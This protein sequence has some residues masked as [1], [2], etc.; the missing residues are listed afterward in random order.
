VAESPLRFAEL[1][2]AGLHRVKAVEGR[3]IQVIQDE[4]GY[5]LGRE[6]G[7]IVEYW[8]KGHLPLRIA[9]VDLLGRTLV[10]RGQLDRD[11]LTAF[12]AAGGHPAPD[13]V[14][15]E[16]FAAV[17]VP[18]GGGALPQADAA[19][20]PAGR[21]PEPS[22]LP[23]GSLM[24]HSR[25]PFF[26]GR[27]EDLL[28][29]ARVLNPQPGAAN[30]AGVAAATGL[31]GI[32]KTQLA[33]EFV[34]RYGQFFPDGVFWLR[35]ELPHAIPAEVARCGGG[36]GLALRPDFSQLAMAEQVAMV[37]AAWQ[38]PER[39]LLIFD[40]CED[41][42]LVQQW[43]P[44][45]GGCR[46]LVTSRLGEWD[47][48]LGV[49]QVPLDVFARAESVALLR[50]H[51][52]DAEEAVFD[53]IAAVLGDLP[54]ALHL[55][56]SYLHRYRRAVTPQEYL[57]AVGSSTLLSHPSLQSAGLSPT[58]HVQH[59]GRTF[60]VSYE[61]LRPDEPRDERAV[62]LL[63]H[64]ACF[65]PGEPV[66]Y[67]VLVQTLALDP[68]VAEDALAAEDAFARLIELG[69]VQVEQEKSIR[70]HRL[71][72]AFARSMAPEHARSAQ[73][74]IEAVVLAGLE[75]ANRTGAPLTLLPGNVHMRHVADAALERDPAEGAVLLAALARHLEQTGD[76]E[77]A[78]SE[79]RRALDV[80]HA[81]LH[82]AE[83]AQC[84][85][86]I[87][88]LLSA[89]SR[90]GEAR[91]QL[92]RALE[93]QLAHSDD[94][95]AATAH[96]LSDLA[97]SYWFEGDSDLA[98]AT[99]ERA[100]ALCQRHLQ[101]D[102]LVTAN[103]ANNLGIMLING[104]ES[105]AEA[106]PY[107][108]QALRIRLQLHGHNHPDSAESYHN[109][110]FVLEELQQLDEARAAYE[111]ALAIRRQIWTDDHRDT[112]LTLSM[113]GALL[114]RMGRLDE[115]R[116]YLEM[117]VEVTNRILGDLDLFTAVSHTKLG[118]NLEASGQLSA[119]R[120]HLQRALAIR[121]AVYGKD[122]LSVAMTLVD[123][124]TLCITIGEA[125]EGKALLIRAARAREQLLGEDHPQTQTVRA[126]LAAHGVG[127]GAH[128]P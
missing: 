53:A 112:T 89:L 64:M 72:A 6:G 37:Q 105:P 126:L 116:D 39:R 18:S 48:L 123:L 111:E 11:W 55:A 119:A 68:S 100:Y 103:V 13:R 102:D 30:R 110:G 26:V 38:G 9:D 14:C 46:I 41:Q 96:I 35:F 21:L 50:Q 47:P 62:L 118:K 52:E 128:E 80:H 28:A 58:A 4:L 86:N 44:V 20:W 65:A 60:A 125:D 94:Q 87:G 106:R 1:L 16:L 70:I 82:G 12:L 108:E 122:T 45:S 78:L 63:M 117:A 83:M 120:S 97:E 22:P 98:L 95:Y 27:T 85:H 15:D 79:W 40:N 43:R 67:D 127:D 10:Q 33:S 124:G 93:L 31:G 2:T 5:L 23:P 34:H 56:G 115:G 51:N 76:L 32:G 114:S 54:L 61:R 59:V 104:P 121:E 99:L 66:W 19:V 49:V 92:E 81:Q 107:L 36:G 74:K 101:A 73:R 42:A 24:P 88:R 113:L 57:E 91:E 7:S 75:R 90:I 69:L 8:R 77:G 71:V 25:N 84:H 109:L 17:A 3:T 29:L